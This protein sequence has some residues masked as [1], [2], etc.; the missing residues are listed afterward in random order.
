MQLALVQ[1]DY[2][3]SWLYN[4][5]T[6]IKDLLLLRGGDLYKPGQF[7]KEM[8]SEFPA[9]GVAEKQ[10]NEIALDEI[11][12]IRD[13]LSKVL[14]K[15]IL[16]DYFEALKEYDIPVEQDLR[17]AFDFYGT[18]ILVWVEP[19]EEDK[20]LEDKLL[21]IEMNINSKYSNQQIE[22]QT[23]VFDKSYGFEFPPQYV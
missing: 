10:D 15:K 9:I 20:V 2:D 8:L 21:K 17:I 1:R 3:Q 22:M 18:G 14:V 11:T 4:F 23:V 5:L 13:N 16:I 19:N 12:V 6:A 7:S